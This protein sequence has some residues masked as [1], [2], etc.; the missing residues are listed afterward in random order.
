MSGEA[1]K[2]RNEYMTVL[3][4]KNPLLRAGLKHLLAD[5]CFA[6]SDKV[7]DEPHLGDPAFILYTQPALFIV[8]A[9][10][11]SEELIEIIRLLKVRQSEARVV[12]VADNF[13]VSFVRSGID[14]G[15]DGFCLGTSDGEVLI[16]SLELVMMGESTLP[17]RLVRSMLNEMTLDAKLDQDR[18]MAMPMPPD[19]GIHKLSN[20]EA[21]IL[22]CL[23][24]G[25]PNKVIAKKLDVAEATIKVH[26]KAILR[27]I[28]AANRT[29]AAMWAREHLA[30]RGGKPQC[31]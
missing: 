23:M 11:S 19:P 28:G 10:N 15:V 9:S 18:P 25:D 13:S 16:K 3:I 27:K 29:Q 26:V 14:A 31:G 20:R 6:V 12:V 8:D 7:F 24:C 22:G 2:D 21:E 1:A 30:T 17:L 5:T 4:S